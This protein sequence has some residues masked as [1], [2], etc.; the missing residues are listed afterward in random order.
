MSGSILAEK[1]SDVLSIHV[2][3]SEEKVKK[4]SDFKT[5]F[6]FRYNEIVQDVGDVVGNQYFGRLNL[7]YHSES[8]EGTAKS[9]E[10][11]SR[12]NNEEVLEYSVK[13]AYIE[14]N[15]G[16]ALSL[17]LGLTNKVL[18]LKHSQYEKFFFLNENLPFFPQATQLIF[19]FGLLKYFLISKEVKCKNCSNNF[20]G[21]ISFS[22]ILF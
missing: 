15:S 20:F 18:Q 3:K 16:Q 10:F 11:K 1:P 7:D 13:E 14:F 12:I 22:F 2:K 5:E 6:G 21:L 9:F 4:S 17:G 8:S 19:D